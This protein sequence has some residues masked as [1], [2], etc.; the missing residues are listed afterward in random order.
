[1]ISDPGGRLVAAAIEDGHRVEPVPGPS[2]VLSALTVSGFAAV[3]FAFL[4]F[5]PRTKGARR[6]LLNSYLARPETLVIFESPRR[7]HASLNELASCF[8]R[9]RGCVARELTKLH[10]EVVRGSLPEL[11]AHFAEGARGEF[12]I[13]VEGGSAAQERAAG[14]VVLS[15]KELTERLRGLLAS[16]RRPREIAALVAR[17][18][19]IPRKQLYARVLA[20]KDEAAT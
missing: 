2:A 5:F 17:E 18:T 8:D 19:A 4:G 13:V 6:E 10:E 12:T 9:R 3:P 1:L 14:Q 15:D 11:A 16:G 7:V 20:L